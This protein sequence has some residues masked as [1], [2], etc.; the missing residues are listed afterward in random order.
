MSVTHT[1]QSLLQAILSAALAGSN[2]LVAAVPGYKIAIYAWS[3]IAAGA[4]AITWKSGA[5]SLSGA[6]NYGIN[7]GEIRDVRA[8]GEPW[9]QTATGEALVLSLG[10]AVQVSG[11]IY[12]RLIPA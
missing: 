2:D 7:G 9:Y 10:G 4:V 11:T 3:F 8:D 1:H 5:T 6:M 12:Y